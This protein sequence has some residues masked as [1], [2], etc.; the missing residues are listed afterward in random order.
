M[1][2][3]CANCSLYFTAWQWQYWVHVSGLGRG[4]LFMGYA[5]DGVHRGRSHDFAVGYRV[6]YC[7]S[8]VPYEE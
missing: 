3:C 1:A 7:E 8:C 5:P 4:Y 6:A 2:Y